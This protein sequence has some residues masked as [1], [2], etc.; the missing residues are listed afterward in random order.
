[1][2]IIA[3]EIK[4]YYTG[5]ASN[6]NP[7]LSKGGVIS[8]VEITSA[9]LHNLFDKVSGAQSTAGLMDYRC[10]GVKNT[11]ATLALES[12]K[13]WISANTPAN[14]DI[15]IGF[16][17]PNSNAVQ[18]I[19]SVTTTPTGIAFYNP[20]TKGTGVELTGEGDTTGNIG[21]GK[22]VAIWVRRTVPAGTA[23][24]SNNTATINVGGDTQG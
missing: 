14:D 8:S 9:S 23:A 12:A 5:G 7:L 19:A 21:T 3:S 18:N 6:N 16:E 22:W 11:N 1:M 10:I 4:F 24:Y 2:A 17:K 13:A 15:A 20:S